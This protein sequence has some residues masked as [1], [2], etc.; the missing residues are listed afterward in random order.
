MEE[1]HTAISVKGLKKSYGKKE[2]FKG[3]K[4]SV[5]KGSIHV[6]LGSNGAGKS[7]MVRILS[8]GLLADFG[9]IQIE[10][11][12]IQKN[13][14]KVRELISLTGQF[15]VVDEM[16]TGRENLVLMGKLYHILSPTQKAEELLQAFDLSKAADDIVSTYSGGMKRK[17]DIAV[18]LVGNPQ[19][20][21]LDEPTTGLD[22]QSRRSMWEMIGKL[23]EK[24]VTIFLTTQYLEEAEV[25]ADR[26]TVLNKGRVLTEGTPL[27]LKEYLPQGA[28]QFTFEDADSGE[29]AE[30]IIKECGCRLLKEEKEGKVMVFTDNGMETLTEL[31]HRF[32]TKGVKMK[33]FEKLVPTLEDVF[34][35]MIEDQEEEE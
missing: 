2:I 12:D 22:P 8:T 13:P 20:L 11:Y 23:K 1:T 26:V 24:G 29:K 6:L 7:T 16:L 5:P 4:F 21:F 31:L 9:E 3:V 33:N 34:L 10:G 32:Y 17:L 25:L 27:Q 14:G 18:S 35:A 28:V 15:S 30:N 19:V